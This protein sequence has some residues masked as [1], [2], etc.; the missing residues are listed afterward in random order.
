M[1]DSDHYNPIAVLERKRITPLGSFLRRYK[2]DEFPQLF[3]IVFGQMCFIGPRP[4]VPNYADKLNE[5]YSI[6]KSLPQE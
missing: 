6:Y 2:I 5:D 4:D 1:V 3:N